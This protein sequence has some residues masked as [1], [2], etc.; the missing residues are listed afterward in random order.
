M[1]NISQ[2]NSEISQEERDQLIDRLQAFALGE[3]DP[4]T[5][6]EMTEIEV[7]EAKLILDQVL[8]DLKI[9]YIHYYYE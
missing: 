5:Q 8:P 3:N 4:L 2:K 7:E 6:V 1:L 9:K